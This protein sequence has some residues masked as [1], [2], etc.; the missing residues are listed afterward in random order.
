MAFRTSSSCA[1]CNCVAVDLD[2]LTGG[3]IRVRQS[4]AGE[5]GAVLTFT[6]QEWADFVAA[7]KLGEFDLQP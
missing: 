2:R 5:D 4:T 7:V 1:T 6:P 3:G